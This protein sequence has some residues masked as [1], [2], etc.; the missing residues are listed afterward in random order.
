[1]YLS[2]IMKFRTKVFNSYMFKLTDYPKITERI[3]F[4]SYPSTKKFYHE[5]KI[6]KGRLRMK[7][8]RA[9]TFK[10]NIHQ[11]SKFIVGEPGEPYCKIPIKHLKL[12]NKFL[13][14]TINDS[15]I[16]FCKED[17]GNFLFLFDNEH[18]RTD[19]RLA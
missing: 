5:L 17:D 13:G 10:V 19:V 6:P 12:L 2:P 14:A 9:A 11:I 1:M 15:K 4:E 7:G 18:Y 3:S 16:E 8:M